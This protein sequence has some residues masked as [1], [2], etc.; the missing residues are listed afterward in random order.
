MHILFLGQHYAPEEVSGAILATQFTRELARRGHQISFVT[1]APSYPKGQVLAGYRNRW[2]QL[3]QMAG[4]RVVRVWSYIHPVKS[5]WRRFL[6]YVT[7]S[8]AAFWGGRSVKKPDLVFSYSPPF[9]L[10][11]SA[12]LLSR[13]HRAPWVL[14]L[15]DMYPEAALAAGVLKNR[16]AVR[17]L[18]W[19][20]RWQYRQAAH[21]SVISPGF[22][23]SLLSKGVPEAKIT[24]TPVWADAGEIT[25]LPKHNAFRLAHQADGRFM[26]LYAGNMGYTSALEDIL[27]A[28]ALLPD[29]Q[30]YLFVLAGEGVKKSAL[31]ELASRLKLANVC[32]LPYQARSTYPLMLAS[33]DLHLVTLNPAAAN[34]SVPGKIF[35]SLASA[36]PVLA[37]TPESSDLAA[38]V[39]EAGCGWITLPGQPAQIAAAIRQISRLPAEALDSAGQQ[40]RAALLSRFSQ[41]ACVQQYEQLFQ[42]VMRDRH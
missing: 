25:P 6:N 4:V 13:W 34:S 36:R 30:R 8:L 31:E 14:R 40:G 28:A 26:I 24:V 5:F 9:P 15:E 29:P 37:V 23:Q 10:G 22:K 19:V 32:F 20:E 27:H 41:A 12:A 7:F 39:R 16:A 11:I 38:I 1:P 3:E 2:L 18:S 42:Q 35:S 33:A 17:I 21:I